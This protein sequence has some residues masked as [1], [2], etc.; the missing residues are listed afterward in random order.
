[1]AENLEGRQGALTPNAMTMRNGLEAKLK[2]AGAAA[3][4]CGK[5]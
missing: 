3:A 5:R 2:T 4:N 1:M